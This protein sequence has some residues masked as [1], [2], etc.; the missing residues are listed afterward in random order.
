VQSLGV[1]NTT[2]TP[3]QSFIASAT[4]KNQGNGSS[5]ST[6]LR[7]YR[8]TDSNISRSDT[9]LS[10]YKFSGLSSNGRFHKAVTLSAPIISGTYWIGACV[11]PVSGESNTTNNCSR[12]VP[13][14]V[15]QNTSSDT[16]PNDPN[17][18]SPGLCG[19]GISDVGFFRDISQSYWAFCPIQALYQEGITSGCGKGNFC[20]N[21]PVTRAQMAVFLERKMNEGTDILS[22]THAIGIFNDVPR[23]H[24]AAKWIEALYNDGITTGCGKGNFCPD[25]PV[26]RAQMAIFLLKTIYGPSYRPGNAH[27]I[28]NDV[29]RYHWAAKWIEAL[30][31]DK[32]TTGCSKGNFCPNKPV[33]RA[34]MAVFFS[35]AFK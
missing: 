17:K 1:S 7:Y 11:D 6:T 25:K 30:Y 23:Y 13:I 33:T 29:P 2:L 3:A 16:C 12:G 8:S 28:F 26:T 24:W 34:Q 21:E 10:I 22:R 19:C 27:G 32:I 14:T 18:E 20:P 31:N 5:P 4:V 15:E 9:R 35:R